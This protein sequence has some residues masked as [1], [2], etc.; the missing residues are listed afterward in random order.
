MSQHLLKTH[1][2]NTCYHPK[3]G[4]THPLSV[5]LCTMVTLRTYGSMHV[6]VM[7]SHV[8]KPQGFRPSNTELIPRII[9]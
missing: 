2:S 9:Y 3:Y 8:Y 6:T 4:G 5:E 1:S 7:A